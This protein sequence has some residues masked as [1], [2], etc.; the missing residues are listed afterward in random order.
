ML[1]EAA[2]TARNLTKKTLQKTSLS[3]DVKELNIIESLASGTAIISGLTQVKMNELLHFKDNSIAMVHSL[4][5]ENVGVVF[6]THPNNLKSGDKAIR[7][8]KVLSVPVGE[9]LLGRVVNPL[10][11]PL[12]NKGTIRS[13]Q[14]FSIAY[15]SRISLVNKFTMISPKSNK[16]QPLP[17][18]PSASSF[19][20]R[21]PVLS[22]FRL[23]TIP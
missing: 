18:L 12:D 8:N 6:L 19:L 13:A 9:A 20:R 15:F 21:R 10:G 2:K 23:H 16:I 14:T 22:L 11:Q 3:M 17:C 4:N 7:T 5:Q 1:K